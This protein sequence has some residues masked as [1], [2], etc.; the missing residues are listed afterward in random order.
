VTASLS[1]VNAWV[2]VI[3]AVAGLLLGTV[4]GAVA[5]IADRLQAR[6]SRRG[7]LAAV[8]IRHRNWH[9]GEMQIPMKQVGTGSF[10]STQEAAGFPMVVTNGSGE[11]I[12]N[13]EYGIRWREGAER[14]AG[15]AA[16]LLPGEK[17]EGTAWEAID[18]PDDFDPHDF[19]ES[20]L[21]RLDFFVRFADQHARRHENI[22]R[23]RPNPEWTS[24]E[25][26]VSPELR[27]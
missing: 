8:G 10:V 27:K 24:E 22:L 1:T 25:L 12:T 14:M 7:D 15:F 5:N 17:E 9:I 20:W 23:H 21:E 16:V 18:A 3:A 2:G 4:L 26:L 6:R 19:D 13:V 11:K